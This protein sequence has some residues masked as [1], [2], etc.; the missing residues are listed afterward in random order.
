MYRITQA[1]YK[2]SAAPLYSHFQGESNQTTRMTTKQTIT[3]SQYDQ[4]IIL[5]YISHK[6][7][8]FTQIYKIVIKQH[9][10]PRKHIANN[11]N[12]VVI[13]N[14]ASGITASTTNPTATKIGAAKQS[15]K[16][17]VMQTDKKTNKQATCTASHRHFI[18]IVQYRYIPISKEK[19]IRPLRDY[20]A[21]QQ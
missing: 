20:P 6:N 3:L 2:N 9:S 5:Y 12:F 8:T 4:T 18:K 15:E 13:N 14:I 7:N 21:T 10:H 17:I 1:L 19:A 11:E 16:E